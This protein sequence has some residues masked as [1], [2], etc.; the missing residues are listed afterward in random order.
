MLQE[1]A[2]I[3]GAQEPDIIKNVLRVVNR[4]EGDSIPV[5]AFIGAED[6]TFPPGTA[7]Y[8][9]RGIAINVPEWIKE[10]CI[11]CNQCSYV[12]PH[13][14]IRPFLLDEEE[15]K[16]AP[17][18]FEMLDAK[19]KGLEGHK[20]RM[21]LS[22]YD[23]T[24][25]GNC[26]ETCPAKQKALVMQPFSTQEKQSALW[27][28]AMTVKPKENLVPDDTLKGSQFKQPL[29]EFSGACAGCGETPYVKL[30]TQLFGDRMLIANA[31]GC[32]SIWGATA[33][34]MPY[35]VNSKGQGPA[36][37]NSLF[38][39]NAEYGYG[40][41]LSFIQQ[42]NRIENL[43]K[44]ALLCLSLDQK[45]KD[46]L[47]EWILYKD[48]GEESKIASEKV[49]DALSVKIKDARA[50][51]IRNEILLLK[52]YLIKKSVWA[53]GGDG[54]AYDIGYGGLDHVLASKRI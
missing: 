33:P 24:G 22:Y 21:Q 45:I 17:E 35:T 37:S 10:N 39:D 2:D 30:V 4:H 9:K 38:E 3:K 36:F 40:M 32:S 25:C 6:G 16:N 42:R 26:V 31:T 14:V 46:A 1:I 18:D 52:D 13:A 49:L 28:F 53:F 15:A 27:D 43:M 44:E 48:N 8:E 34:S 29:L 7:A 51:E 19:G 20:Y 23:C 5:S 54:W 12:C 41:L 50:E 47:N 11:Q